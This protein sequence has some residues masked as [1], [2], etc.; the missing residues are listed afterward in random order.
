MT[1]KSVAA[2]YGVSVMKVGY[3]Q[4]AKWVAYRGGNGTGEPVVN[5]AESYTL[6]TLTTRIARSLAVDAKPV[7]KPLI[8]IL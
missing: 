6:V 2:K 8:E 5:V 4:R 3:G 7:G 1:A